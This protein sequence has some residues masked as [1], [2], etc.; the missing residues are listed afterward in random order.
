MKYPKVTV[1][2]LGILDENGEIRSELLKQ[3]FRD[4]KEKYI[5]QSYPNLSELEIKLLTYLYASEG[6]VVSKDQLGDLM[7]LGNHNYSLWAIYKQI[8]RL[9]PKISDRF[10]IENIKG[11]GYMLVHS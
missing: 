2:K 7:L 10:V 1:S 6:N 11:K 8:S 5:E 9:K 4:Y 3:Y